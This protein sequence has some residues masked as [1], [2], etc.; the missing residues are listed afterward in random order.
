MTPIP[1]VRAAAL[2]GLGRTGG[3]A[4][5]AALEARL[6]GPG[7][8]AT[9]AAA[10]LGIAGVT[11][12][13]EDADRPAVTAALVGLLERTDV[14]RA[15]VLEALGRA[16]DAGARGALLEALGGEPR[17]AA[18][19]AVALGRL[20]RR[21]IALDPPLRAKL[22]A[23]TVAPDCDLRYGATYALAR[24]AL[25]GPGTTPPPAAL[26]DALR[27]RLDDDDHEVRATAVAGLARRKVVA[28]VQ[29]SLL[30]RL[31]DADWRVVVEVERAL[32]GDG[33][34]E[35]GRAAVVTF[36][37]RAWIGL[38]GATPRQP[39]AHV[40]LEALRLAA[41]H[42]GE[43]PVRAGV[44]EIAAQGDQ[45]RGTTLSRAWATCL[46]VQDLAEADGVDVH[47]NDH[48]R[49]LQTCGG[50]VLAGAAHGALLAATLGA[51]PDPPEVRWT[52][53]RHLLASTDARVA[54]PAIAAAARLW[55]AAP[56]L[57]PDI[58]REIAA[59]VADP[60]VAVAEA[61]ADG[62]GAILGATDLPADARASLGAALL[63][64][65]HRATDPELLVTIFGDLAAA[66]VVGADRVCEPARRHP[67]AAV[68]DAARACMTAVAGA[69]PGPAAPSGPPPTPPVD[70]AA[71]LGHTV[72]WT[73][74]T[75]RGRIVIALEPDLAPWHVAAIIDLTRRRFYDGLTWHR[76]VPGFVIQGG[77]PTG[78]G[79]GG[80]GYTLPA[81]PGSRLG[82]ATFAAGAVGIA[83]AGKD[84]GG[85]Q[86]F[87]MQARAPH[88]EG[89]YTRIG[90][91]VSGQ[92]VVDAI[93]VGD[94]I[95]TATVVVR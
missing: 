92:D 4:A 78:T 38:R 54:A 65:G 1:A 20:G 17:V 48:L 74:D 24:E 16:G 83:D 23:L 75:T 14:D 11:G 37:V 2:R 26:I 55:T 15:V 90:H 34:T 5:V 88:L 67:I 66:K 21:G 64:G 93:Q 13:L 84:T 25:G 79:S 7:P 73:V 58:Q 53:L 6:A 80:P 35:T 70:P 43:A 10:A 45:G 94:R 18:V 36:A 61:A 63:D 82:G 46:A 76:V 56:A 32:A 39:R 71:G 51:S 59:R 8:D 91:V 57:R 87:V 41:G 52:V 12:G 86:W 62:L 9:A 22:A 29:S 33:G 89:R 49:V 42:L 3:P 60:R 68:A 81:E 19:A 85:S 44:A 72:T 28:D 77:D 50:D 27:A 95:T 47:R 69:D 40:V 31:R 30:D